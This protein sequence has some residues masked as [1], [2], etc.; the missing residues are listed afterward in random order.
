MIQEVERE[1]RDQIRDISRLAG[2]LTHLDEVGIV[3]L[4][5]VD[6]DLPEIEARRFRLEM[7][8]TNHRRLISG[9]LQQLGKGHLAAVELIPVVAKPVDVAV[10]A[11]QK[12]GTAGRAQRVRA[13]SCS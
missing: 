12:D 7:P 2:L 1:V 3:V 6:Q 11:R 10:L 4:A 9:F 13:R 8:F 5:L